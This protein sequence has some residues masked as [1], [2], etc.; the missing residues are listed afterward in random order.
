MSG[1]A[2]GSVWLPQLGNH[3][4]VDIFNN[5]SLLFL[6]LKPTGLRSS[7]SEGLLG[8]CVISSLGNLYRLLR[9]VVS[10]SHKDASLLG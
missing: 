5:T 2:D 1:R 6:A 8:F 9:S 4:L 3:V 10:L 7:S